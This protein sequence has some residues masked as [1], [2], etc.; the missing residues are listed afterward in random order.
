MFSFSSKASFLGTRRENEGERACL[1]FLIKCN[2]VSL[3]PCNLFQANLVYFH[4]IY[5]WGFLLLL[6]LHLTV[7][8]PK[9]KLVYHSGVSRII[10]LTLLRTITWE[11][12]RMYFRDSLFHVYNGGNVAQSHDKYSLI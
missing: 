7:L 4:K 6:S 2:S 10:N 12:Y 3:N 5:L 11:I 8:E 1:S 9:G